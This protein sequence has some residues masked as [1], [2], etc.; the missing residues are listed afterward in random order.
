MKVRRLVVKNISSYK[1]RTEFVFDGGINILIG[2]NG[3]GKTNCQKIISLTLSKYFI[4]QYQF[5]RDNEVVSVEVVDPWTKRILPQIFPKFMGDDG[6]QLI[7]IELAPE[8][9]DIENI[10]AIGS[11]LDK[12]NQQLGFWEK[13][14]ESYAPL[15]VADAIDDSDSFTF[16]IRNLELEEPQAGTA[17]W[18]FREYLREFFIFLR[19]AS[20]IPEL[21]LSS[22][23]FFFSSDRAL[24]RNFEVQAGNL[25]EQTQFDGYRSAYQ[26]ATG[27][28]MNL[29][30]WGAQ[31]FVRLHRRA[32]ID[33]S[34]SDKQWREFFDASPDVQL[35][36]KYIRQ[37]GYGWGFNFDN[38]QLSYW[39]HLIKDN[40]QL[41]TS[42]FSSG[43]REIVHF[44][45][46]MFALNVQDGLILVD[47][48][49]LHLHPRWQKIFLRLFSRP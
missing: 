29:M 38:D 4:H 20:Q 28:S 22:P 46:A 10:R 27:E 48:P 44:L 23:V 6:E 5:R 42:M 11:N 8:K 37:L 17:A 21:S 34:K 41:P 2:P 26:A 3:G 32:V 45:L 31:H 47:E 33:S 36:S 43:E 49:E 19:V 25:S 1:E 13:H 40:E 30:Q 18:G 24:Q 39:F 12:L 16:V 35:L 15:E 7:E 14:Y 9:N